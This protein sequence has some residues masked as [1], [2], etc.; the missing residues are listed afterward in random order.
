MNLTK[1][2]VWSLALLGAT[3]CKKQVAPTEAPQP[4]LTFENTTNLE[5]SGEVI[6]ITREKLNEVIGA[7]SKDSVAVVLLENN[8]PAIYQLEDINQDGIWDE[9]LVSLDLKANETKS[10]VVKKISK[11]EAPKFENNTNVRFGVGKEK[12]NVTEVLELE[13]IGDPRDNKEQFFQMEGPA[14]END[15]VGF[16]F[17]FDPRNGI[18]IFG[19]TTPKMVLDGV[20]LH[21][22][23][24]EIED[25]GM[26]VLKVGTSLGAGAIA[27]KSDNQLYRV[28]G[29]EK[30][31]F[32]V[33]NEGPL[34]ATFE[35][36][37]PETTI[38]EQK[39]N[40]SHLISITKGEWGY[41]SKLMFSGASKTIRAVS[42][43][44]NLKPNQEI[45][46]QMNDFFVLKSHG[47]QSE[48]KDY[49]GM[50][51]VVN[52]SDYLQSYTLDK[53]SKDIT[54]S[55]LVEMT[56]ENNQPLEFHFL[57]GWEQSNK[58]FATAEGFN[59]MINEFTKKKSNP[60]V[61]R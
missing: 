36:K 26:D 53:E 18:D 10:L 2:I 11:K 7:I 21:S 48:N 13:R 58:S 37:Y 32:K 9:Y 45:S 27:F 24:H 40:V 61:V 17:Y 51:V 12:P 29:K 4:T 16:R 59:A 35:M 54:D 38:G 33:L 19:K 55:Y 28:T 31:I 49:L 3:S 8:Q 46:E 6:T 57:T 44:V 52:K 1:N 5:R 39:L 42:G 60:I 14:W 23:Y 43:I 34:R 47:K 20:G 22:N 30:T 41:K 50:A 15:K 25:W 56:I